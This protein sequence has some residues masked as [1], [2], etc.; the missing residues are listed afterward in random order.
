MNIIITNRVNLEEGHL[1]VPDNI[2]VISITDPSESFVNLS[3]IESRVPK[4]RLVFHDID[5]IEIAKKYKLVHFTKQ[6]ANEI[7]Y[8]LSLVRCENIE[9]AVIQCNAGISRSAGVA[10][11][12]ALIINGD[13][14]VIFNDKRYLPNRLVYRTILEVFYGYYYEQYVD[15]KEWRR[16]YVEDLF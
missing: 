6:M 7:I 14:S 9:T 5:D 12:I 15:V 3:M 2:A 8:W 10:A 1:W 16:D 13:D 4:L 11:A